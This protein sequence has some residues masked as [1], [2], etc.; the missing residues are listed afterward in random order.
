MKMLSLREWSRLSRVAGIEPGFGACCMTSMPSFS[1]LNAVSRTP[2][3]VLA[4]AGVMLGCAMD[5]MVKSLGGAYSVILIAAGRYAFGALFAGIVLVTSRAPLPN[6]ES[7]PAHALRALII[8]ACALLFFNCLTLLPIAEA[9]M[10]IF[11]APLMIAP[12]ARML[13][14]EPMRAASSG[15]LLLGFAGV[16]VTVH[17]LEGAADTGRRLEGLLSGAAAAVLYALSMVLL[18]QMGPK[19][20]P[21]TIAF[22]SNLIPA[23]YLVPVAAWL[24]AAPATGDV[25]LFAMTGLAGFLMWFCLTAAYARA[26]AQDIAPAEYTALIWSAALGFIFFA[27]VPR[28]QA[29]AGAGIIVLGM[30]LVTWD[31]RRMP[32]QD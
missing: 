15:A 7:L 27:E 20:N 21:V 9:T 4:T 19:N 17:G 13:L 12:L 2:P 22:L 23:L 24:G 1:L 5:A 14:G 6:R 8:A 3:I 25:L 30:M 31:S 10:L 26:P 11:S 18:R 28:W 16:L 29:W 32:R